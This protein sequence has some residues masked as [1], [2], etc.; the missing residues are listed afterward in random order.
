MTYNP[1]TL[2]DSELIRLLV[3]AEHLAFLG[4]EA[5]RA[6]VQRLRRA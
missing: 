1:Y 5:P 4:N 2:P 3:F 6:T